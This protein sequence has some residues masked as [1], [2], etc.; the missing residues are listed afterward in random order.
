M[1]T[2]SLSFR[3]RFEVR[4]AEVLQMEWDSADVGV[5]HQTVVVHRFIH[6]LSGETEVRF[7]WLKLLHYHEESRDARVE[8]LNGEIALQGEGQ[9]T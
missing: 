5:C 9:A 4:L 3:P 8:G 7:A 2:V 1:Y 6:H